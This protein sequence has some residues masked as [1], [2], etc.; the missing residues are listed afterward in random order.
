MPLARP[1]FAGL[2]VLGAAAFI[3]GCGGG[4]SDLSAAEFRSQADAI[5]ADLNTQINGLT[6]PTS[7]ATFLPFLRAGLPIQ[8]AQ[9]KK[10]EALKPPSDL[11]AT[12]AE[13]IDLQKQQVAAI[14]SAADR[15]AGGESAE[16]VVN[17]VSDDIDAI[18][19]KADAKAKELGLNVCGTEKTSAGTTAT[20]ATTPDATAPATTTAP[21][22]ST[23]ASGGTATPAAYVADV[24]VATTALKS[25]GELL[26]SSTS[27]QD[28]GSKAGA[29]Q[30]KLDQFDVAIA[31]L[32]TYSLDSKQLD[33]QRAGLAA[34]GPEVSDVLRRFLTAAAANDIAGISKLVPEVTTAIG[35]FQA[36]A[37]NP[38]GTTGTTTG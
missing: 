27:L 9:L 12:Y 10:L 16:A 31:K 19:T 21:A 8:E 17:D 4:S 28:L 25:F 33:T 13:A 35:K 29:A 34:T 11:K 2:A 18:N 26:Q 7:A 1:V 5:C 3:A 24:Q 14:T 20:T 30:E 22:T 37:T 38:G 23:T 6:E 32:G 15:I 36:A